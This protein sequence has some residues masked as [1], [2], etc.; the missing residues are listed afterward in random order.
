M[1]KPIK[2][3]TKLPG[4]IVKEAVVKPLGIEPQRPATFANAPQEAL[5]RAGVAPKS[6]VSLGGEDQQAATTAQT[7]R[8][9]A[10]GMQ[11]SARG[12][13]T[14]ATTERKRLLGQ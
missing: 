1:S 11:T 9:R 2:Q 12:V 7:R 3:I 5:E 14:A 8:R 10:A 13:T 4:K 6:A